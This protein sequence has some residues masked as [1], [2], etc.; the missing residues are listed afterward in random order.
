MGFFAPSRLEVYPV[1]AEFDETTSD[2]AAICRRPTRLP[3]NRALHVGR[4]SG[5]LSLRL[6]VDPAKGVDATQSSRRELNR[7]P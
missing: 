2:H 1:W 7:Y 3:G 4:R 5:E 6:C